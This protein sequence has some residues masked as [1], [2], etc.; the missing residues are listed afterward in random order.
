MLYFLSTISTVFIRNNSSIWKVPCS[1]QGQKRHWG[2][3]SPLTA[4]RYLLEIWQNLSIIQYVELIYGWFRSNDFI[5]VKIIID[6]PQQFS[7]TIKKIIIQYIQKRKGCKKKTVFFKL[8][9]FI[10][11]ITKEVIRSLLPN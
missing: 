5:T 10:V 11:M 4:L 1:R 2:C 7:V 8:M 3:T 9:L 6:K